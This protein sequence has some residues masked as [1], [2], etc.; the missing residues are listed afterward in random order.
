[1]VFVLGPDDILFC[2]NGV[3]HTAVTFGTTVEG[4]AVVVIGKR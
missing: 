2:G 1:L 3:I 4:K